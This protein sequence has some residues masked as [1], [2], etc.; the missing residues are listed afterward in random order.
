MVCALPAE[1]RRAVET[2]SRDNVDALADAWHEH[3][4]DFDVNPVVDGCWYEHALHELNVNAVAEIVNELL[5]DT[6]A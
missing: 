6:P 4:P 5:S 1:A 3:V 2:A